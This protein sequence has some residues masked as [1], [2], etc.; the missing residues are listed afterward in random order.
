VL[1]SWSQ[2]GRYFSVR[3]YLRE[4]ARPPGWYVNF[5][6][7]YRRTGL[8][9]DTLDLFLDLVIGPN[10]DRVVWKDEGEY[11]QARR[12][13]LVGDAVHAGVQAAREK[14]NSGF[15]VEIERIMRT[16]WAPATSAFKV[17]GARRTERRGVPRYRPRRPGPR[18]HRRRSARGVG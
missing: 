7:P 15:H 14:A 4:G 1:V 9:I 8:G 11:A 6:V 13:G 18:R 5:E 3:R 12:L 16:L 17:V 10:L 2:P